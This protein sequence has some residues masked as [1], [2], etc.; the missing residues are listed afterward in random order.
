MNMITQVQQLTNQMNSLK[1][2]RQKQQEKL[3]MFRQR[4]EETPKIEQGYMALQRD[5]Q[6]AHAKYQEVM[7]KLLEA[8]ISEGMEQHQ[9]GEKFTLVDPASFPEEPIKPNKKMIVLAGL[10]LGLGSGLVF[11]LGRENLD[12]SIK[13]AE[14]LAG[15]TK[16]MP[17]GIIANITTV[18]IWPGSAGGGG[19]F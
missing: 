1:Q 7:N 12:T 8:R 19:C 5:Y 16:T 9:K 6:N 11:M 14:E 3:A 18:L 17:L 4:L 15:L 2:L 13:S 10:F